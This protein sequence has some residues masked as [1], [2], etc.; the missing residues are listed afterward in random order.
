MTEVPTEQADWRDLR[1]AVHA[2]LALQERLAAVVEQQAFVSALVA[3][4]AQHGM[5]LSAAAAA[6]LIGPDMLGIERFNARP[7]DG[8][9]WH[10]AHAA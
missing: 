4:A 1:A 3:E 7:P 2:D 5:A 8:S 10:C 9:A 6:T